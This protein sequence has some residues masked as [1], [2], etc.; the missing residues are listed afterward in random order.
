VTATTEYY[1]YKLEVGCPACASVSQ[2]TRQLRC[3]AVRHGAHA[4]RADAPLSV[5][6]A[7]AALRDAVAAPSTVMARALQYAQQVTVDWD[8]VTAKE[9]KELEDERS[10]AHGGGGGGGLRK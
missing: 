9:E 2:F 7:A 8:V 1:S 6:A 5:A 10:R 3:V 4:D